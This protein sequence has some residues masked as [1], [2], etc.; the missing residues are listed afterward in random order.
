MKTKVWEIL[1]NYVIPLGLGIAVL[2]YL[3]KIY[4]SDPATF[5]PRASLII[6]SIAAIFAGISARLASRSLEKT[7]ESLKLTRATTRPFL[8]VS[9]PKSIVT[10]SSMKLVISNTGSLPADKVEILCTLCTMENEDIKEY[11]LTPWKEEAPSIYFPGDEVGPTYLWSPKEYDFVDDETR[12]KMRIRVMIDYR[13]KLTQ[14][15]HR[16]KRM[17]M[18]TQGNTQYVYQLIPIPE[19][20]YWD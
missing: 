13:N 17:F 15:T 2:W 14:K 20:D 11:K 9:K 19:E 5:W 3:V 4:Q 7:G 12:K 1:L 8:N 10:Q 18:A 16:T 6:V